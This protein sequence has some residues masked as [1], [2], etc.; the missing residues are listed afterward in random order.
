[1]K[2]FLTLSIIVASTLFTNVNAQTG[3]ALNFD[4]T[5]DFVACG[6]I[7]GTSYTKEAWVMITN[8]A[9]GN[10]FIS[11]GVSDGRHAFWA[12]AMYGNRLSAGHNGT[13]NAVQDPT[14]LT[15]GVW[16]HVAVTYNSAT[17][18][19]NLYKNGVLVSTNAAVPAYING[20]G[21]RLGSYDVA[22]NTLAGSMDEV[23]IWNFPRSQAQ[24]SSNMSCPLTSIPAG[25]LQYYRFNQGVAAGNNAGLTTLTDIAGTA[26]NGT[27]TN[28]ALSGSTSNW[29]TPGGVPSAVSAIISSQTNVTCNGA[30][31]GTATVSASGGNSF[32]YAWAPSGGTAAT[33]TGLAPGTYTCTVTNNCSQ[34]VT[35][36][37]LITQP[38]V[39]TTAPSGGG[40]ICNG[41]SILLS[42][43]ASG[44]TPPYTYLWSPGGLTGASENVSPSSTTTYSTIV[45]DNNGCTGSFTI[46]VTVNQNPTIGVQSNPA[47]GQVCSGNQAT[48][49]ANGAQSYMW[50]GGISNGV[51]FTP[52]STTTYSVTGTDINGCTGTS[53]ATIT[54]NNC[55]GSTVPCGMTIN[56]KNQ[57]LSAANVPNATQYRFRFYDNVTLALV[58]QVTQASR[59]LTFSSVPGI[60]Y[61]TTYRWTV[62]VNTGSGIGPESSNACTITFAVPQTTVSCGA[63]YNRYNGYS[64][65]P[66]V[67]GSTG[68]R[69]TFYDNVTLSQ[70]AQ[71]AQTSNYIYFNPIT[72]LQP[73]TTYRWT[74]ETQ[75]NN[76]SGNVYGPPSNMN[77]TVNMLAPTTTVPCDRV[78]NKITGYT[79]CPAVTGATGYRFSFYQGP[80]LI[81]QRTQTSN[82]IYFNNVVGIYNNQSYQW[83]VEVQYNP[84]SGNVFGPASAPC[85]ITF[86]SSARYSNPDASAEPSIEG[87]A[88]SI[89]PNPVSG[90]INPSVTITGA[91][92]QEAMVNIVDLTGRTIATY[93]LFVQG[94]VYTAELF[95][96]PELVTGMYIMQVQVGENVRSEKF[97]KE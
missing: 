7:L 87:F 54:V 65:A 26:Q 96:F 69:F 51:P 33:A 81:A 49:T 89:Y 57:T 88:A 19:M 50:T 94:G 48:L 6:N 45:T 1:M 74:V 44:G 63:S 35:C 58:G 83:T 8:A 80:T 93:T 29:I 16:Y 82:Y 4:G 66:A 18:T 34:T 14:P 95:D 79:T 92:Q 71:V 86:S 3:D 28:F 97:I 42:A 37:V 67:A 23:R 31:D 17:T 62:A 5:N 27:L 76:G 41:Q 39:V 30:N 43:N 22:T 15:L 68:Y 85:N 38:S 9:N 21:V 47:N 75:Y 56:N 84:G 70:V 77:C 52:V 64:A 78:Y 20:G 46:N 32:S 73:G 40:T 55:G 13:W 59:T 24:I 90:G 61:G 53:Q 36:T 2:K 91:D 60:L 72:Q 10:N 25:L 11:G 12:P